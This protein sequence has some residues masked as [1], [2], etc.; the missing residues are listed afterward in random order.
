MGIHICGMCQPS[1]SR[2][3]K[4]C[5]TPNQNVGAIQCDCGKD[6]QI[7]L[8]ECPLLP[9]PCKPDDLAV[10]YS[11]VCVVWRREPSRHHRTIIEVVARVHNKLLYCHKATTLNNK[12]LYCHKATTVN[13]LL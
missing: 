8:L 11:C 10:Y 9:E 6:A 4:M 2:R 12:L 3:I 7:I 13:K 1:A 5:G